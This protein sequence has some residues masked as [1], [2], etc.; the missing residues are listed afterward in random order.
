MKRIE[1]VFDIPLDKTF[2]YLPG[3]FSG[4]ISPGMR[5]RV[6]FGRQKKTGI[7]VSF[8]E[9]EG[10]EEASCKEILKLSDSCPVLTEELFSLAVFLSDRYFSSL[11]QALFS[12]VGGL[13]PCRG[14]TVA[15][16][17][18]ISVAGK[19]GF[20]EEHIILKAEE[21]R[22]SFNRSLA[23]KLENGSVIFL[24]PEVFQAE[25]FH[26][27]MTDVIGDRAILF[28]GELKPR[29]R[30]SAWSEMLR[31][32]NILV[33]GTRL[34]VFAPMG[35]IS[36][37][38]VNNSYDS[39][40]REQQ[41]P[42]YEAWEVAR[43]RASMLGV[44]IFSVDA[45]L[46]VKTYFRL[47]QGSLPAA[48]EAAGRRESNVCIVRTGR[49]NVDRK[50][51]FL[52]RDSVS[53]M[54]ESILKEEKVAIIHN[55]R[56][57][58]R[59]LKCE[60]CEAGFSCRTCDSKL[61]LSEDGKTL[62]CRFCATAIPF[63]KKCPGC[64]SRKVSIRLYG[65]EKMFN[66]LKQEYPS[67]R[68]S[69]VTSKITEAEAGD[70][71]LLVG[72]TAVK[73]YLHKHPF[74]LVIFVS[75]ESFLNSPG[76]RS[77]E[78]FFILVNEISALLSKGGGRIILQSR[79]PVME[80]YR[81]LSEGDPGFFL[82]KEVLARKSLGYPPCTE[83]VKAELKGK[84]AGILNSKKKILEDY[85]GEK[86]IA[87]IYSGPSFPPVK[88]GKDTWKYLLRPLPGFDRRDLRKKAYE[89]GAVLESDP[90]RI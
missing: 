11:G 54:E 8:S 18:A 75:S 16:G 49:K 87:V 81:S 80:L 79:N 65:I 56:G 10:I 39:S 47:K 19:E 12:M 22:G 20:K 59:I 72:T 64:G 48:G 67:V 62:L 7:V 82:E 71:S 90:D 27:E 43:Y 13:A 33:S 25:S 17:S 30:T 66:I 5:I 85:F 6:P 60:K 84:K 24:F 51:S 23:G 45:S 42:R 78:H 9:R 31:G 76:Y 83:I 89:A 86:G 36:A 35:D 46:S 69:R 37:F 1:T 32:K 26:R 38:V 44:P 77:E 15:P 21:D 58:S 55:N 70:F 50:L 74:G 40:Y 28:H 73:K 57:G 53:M 68:I 29:R 14:N 52:S 34:A 63:E 41:V 61:V 88:K 2:D 4:S 3:P